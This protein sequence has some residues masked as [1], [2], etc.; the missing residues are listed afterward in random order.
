M[1]ATYSG[2]TLIGY[3]GVSDF[4]SSG[5]A[6][7]YNG[8]AYS[9]AN[10]MNGPYTFWSFLHM[11]SMSLSGNTATFFNAL[12]DSIRTNAVSSS[13][14]TLPDMNVNRDA[15]GAAVYESPGGIA[16]D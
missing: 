8:A 3:L 16:L 5:V 2:G 6:L 15:D 10:I 9:D 12:K 7:T 11:N 4:A 1:N 14:I 13:M